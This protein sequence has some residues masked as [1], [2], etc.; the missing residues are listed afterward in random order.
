M[1]ENTEAAGSSSRLKLILA[2][3]VLV[4]IVVGIVSFDVVTLLKD[5]LAWINGLGA[6]GA[7]AFLTIYIVACVLL[8]PASVLTVGAGFVYGVVYGTALVSVSSILGAT[9][10][11][12]TGRYL[13]RDWVSKKIEANRG[14]NAIDEAVAREGWKIV[15]LIRL[16]PLIPF[17]LLNYMLGLTKVSVSHYF[18]AS[19]IGMLPGTVLYVYLG[20]LAGDLA[21]VGVGGQRSP[22]EWAVSIIGLLATVAVT[23]YV[24]KIARKALQEKVA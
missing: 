16:S 14:F 6:L 8:V 23:I 3:A 11:F 18:F 19:W 1:K 2:A 24:T 22:A 4:L 9:A 13:A 17:N 10:A 15:G 12:L 21:T 20:S 7:L 5:F